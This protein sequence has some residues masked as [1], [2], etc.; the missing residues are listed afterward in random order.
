MAERGGRE[1]R[2]G[3]YLERGEHQQGQLPRK[4][5]GHRVSRGKLGVVIQAKTIPENRNHTAENRSVS[6]LLLRAPG[7]GREGSRDCR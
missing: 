4:L 5:Q 7:P 6:V 2:A 3:D 1:A